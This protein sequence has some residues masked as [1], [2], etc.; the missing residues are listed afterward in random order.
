MPPALSRGVAWAS[1]RLVKSI[2]LTNRVVWYNRGGTQEKKKDGGTGFSGVPSS[3]P[4][5]EPGVWLSWLRSVPSL[6]EMERCNHAT[7]QLV[8]GN[9]RG[10]ISGANS[11]C[12][13][14]ARA[15]LVKASLRISLSYLTAFPSCFGF[16]SGSP[17]RPSVLPSGPASLSRVPSHLPCPVFCPAFPA[18]VFVLLWA[19]ASLPVPVPARLLLLPSPL[20][21]SWPRVRGGPPCR[22]GC[23]GGSRAP[24]RASVVWLG[25]SLPL[26]GCR[27]LGLVCV[28]GSASA[29]LAFPL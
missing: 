25:P 11:A 28:A 9:P 21:L 22:V 13:P 26:P 18:S 2:D 10:G 15:G 27:G 16:S 23:S 4:A 14:E 5:Q 7:L 1:R 29:G 8:R 6:W 24:S 3:Q 20:P 12:V 17:A 19:A